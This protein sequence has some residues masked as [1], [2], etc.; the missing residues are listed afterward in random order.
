[1]SGT[2][3]FDL[4]LDSEERAAL[5]QVA[6]ELGCSASAWIRQLIRRTDERDRAIARERVLQAIADLQSDELT[7]LARSAEG[8]LALRRP[9]TSPAR[10][11]RARKAP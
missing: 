9:G 6:R 10:S 1:M 5:R 11:R 4:R 7:A 8:L 2:R 3:R